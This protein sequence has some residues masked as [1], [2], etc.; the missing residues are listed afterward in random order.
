MV[1]TNDRREKKCWGSEFYNGIVP[2]VAIRKV[3]GRDGKLSKL[4]IQK[5]Q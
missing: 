1:C 4:Y 3:K 2:D 5:K